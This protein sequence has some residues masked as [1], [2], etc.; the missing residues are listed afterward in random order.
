MF[1]PRPGGVLCSRE[2]GERRQ[3]DRS[4]QRQSGGA[5]LPPEAQKRAPG[6]DVPALRLGGWVAREHNLIPGNLPSLPHLTGSRSTIRSDQNKKRYTHPMQQLGKH[7]Q[8]LKDLRRRLR[9]RGGEVFVDGARLVDDLL[10]WG[11]AIRELYLSAACADQARWVEGAADCFVI[12]EAVF[13]GLAPTRNPQGFLAVVGEPRWPAWSPEGVTLFL[14]GIQDPG[15]L[16]AIVRSS[17]GLGAR[18]VLLGPGCADPFGAVAVRGSAGAVFRLP[19]HREVEPERVA[20]EVA[21]CGGEVWAAGSDGLP[22]A[23]WRPARPLLLLLGTEG[24]GLSEKAFAVSGG[25]VTI[26][27]QLE[28]ESLNVAVAAGILARHAIETTS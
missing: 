27:L 17:A 10:R 9:H 21:A 26:P 16:G 18:A 13:S 28:I 15:N 4:K 5:W 7:S 6:Q 3:Q 25:T 8:R 1:W 19:V 14:D 20:G 23:R 24:K 2:L 11:V 12:D 22:I